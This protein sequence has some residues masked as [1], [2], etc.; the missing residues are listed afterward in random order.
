MRRFRLSYPES[1]QALERTA[2]SAGFLAVF[3][4]VPVGCRS[5][6]ALA[7]HTLTMN[8]QERTET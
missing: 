6:P 4:P 1:N 2:H 3:G 5:P 7:G 8:Y